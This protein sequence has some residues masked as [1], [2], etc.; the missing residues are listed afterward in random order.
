MS[1]VT[2]YGSS[3]SLFTGRARSYLIKSAIPYRETTPTTDHFRQHVVPAA[4]G[5]HSIPTI[6]TAEGEVIRDGAAIIDYFENANG[7]QYSPKT[8]KHHIL[9]LL[10]D[11]IGAEGMLRPAMHYRW[12]FPEKNL[13][14][15]QFHFESM[16]PKHLDRKTTAEKSMNQ[17]RNACQA[18]GAVPDTFE[19]V[20]TLYLEL[21]EKLDRHFSAQPYLLGGKPCIGDFGM[22]APLFGHLGRDPKPLS[23]MQDKTIRLFRWVERMNRPELD[24]G[25]FDLQDGN[26]L[27]GDAVPES[28]IN[29][30]QHLA[31]DFIPETRAAADRVNQWIDQQAELQPS[32]IAERGV[33]MCSFDIRGAT[34]NALA[35]PYRFYLLQRVQDSYAALDA[36]DKAEVKSLLDDCHMSEILDL[37]LSRRMGRE[38]NREVWL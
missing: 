4:G 17:M 7:Q 24:V 21:I 28:L 27:A 32:T 35:Q 9:S 25:E 34:I 14:F 29:V 36:T 10:F 37:K 15:L 2:L 16:M 8:P 18:F 22:I 5:R 23:I 1:I 3:L 19:L 26:Y 11:V 12:N 30:L 31:L 20:E 6:E 13:N 33:G 38:N